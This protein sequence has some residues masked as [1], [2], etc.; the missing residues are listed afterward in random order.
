MKN[1][2]KLLLTKSQKTEK[3]NA[4]ANNMLTDIK[5]SKA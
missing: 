2:H 5:F 1:N 4:F 3:R